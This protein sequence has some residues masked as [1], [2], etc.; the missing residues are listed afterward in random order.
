METLSSICAYIGELTL[1]LCMT[2]PVGARKRREG[3]KG[4][5]FGLH[6]KR[7]SLELWWFNE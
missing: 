6:R 3:G 5:P 2:V 1:V 7:L 4:E